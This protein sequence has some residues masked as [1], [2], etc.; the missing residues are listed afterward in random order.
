MLDVIRRNES[1]KLDVALSENIGNENN[2]MNPEHFFL[3]TADRQLRH[4]VPVAFRSVQLL[5]PGPRPRN[6]VCCAMAASDV[7]VAYDAYSAG[8]VVVWVVASV[9]K[10]WCRLEHELDMT[11]YVIG[12]EAEAAV[13]QVLGMMRNVD[14]LGGN[15]VLKVGLE[16]MQDE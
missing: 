15:L 16:Y 13:D 4:Y 5:R 2:K 14:M 10:G 1:S 9:E 8:S 3:R 11:E 7:A 6:P 12:A